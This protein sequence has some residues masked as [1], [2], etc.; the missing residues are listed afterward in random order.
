MKKIT[1]IIIVLILIMSMSAHAEEAS[2]VDIKS[3]DWFYSNVSELMD[4]GLISGYPDN[5]FKPQ[6][7][8][9]IDEFLKM[10]IVGAGYEPKLVPESTY[11]AEGYILKAKELGIVDDTFIDDYRFH[12][13]RE[14]AAR[15]I[16]N[17]L[18]LNESKPSSGYDKHIIN[19]MFDYHLISDSF[20]QDMLDCYGF[21]IMQGNERVEMRPQET[22]TRAETTAVI[23]RMMNKEKRLAVEFD[24]VKSIEV[25]DGNGGTY[26]AVAPLHNGKVL[27]ELIEVANLLYS[28][29]SKGIESISGNNTQISAL[30]YETEERS[31]IVYEST[32]SGYISDEL[33]DEVVLWFNWSFN[34]NTLEVDGKYS[35]YSFNTDKSVDSIVDENYH[36]K[37]ELWGKFF[38]EY[39]GSTFQEIFKVLFEDEYE[40]AWEYFET[41]I[42]SQSSASQRIE[43]EIN[44]RN[45]TISYGNDGMQMS[46]S[47]KMY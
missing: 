15:I 16:V 30:A 40:I 25:Y 23:L 4:Y 6:N 22:I 36:R 35:P 39:Y 11:W 33:F 32:L 26:I 20:K 18:S 17:T 13:T 28:N 19:A 37:T 46:I 47:L 24:G 45:F 10:V 1:S 2:L 8:V 31:K 14:K 29:D 44:D 42:H 43:D 38:E 3:T 9:Q 21:G 27:N 7:P 5:T 34:I 41:A 12:L